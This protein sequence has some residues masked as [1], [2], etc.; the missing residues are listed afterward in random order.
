ML[1]CSKQTRRLS[2]SQMERKELGTHE[3]TNSLL[4]M[5]WKIAV[6]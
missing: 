3:L 6:R 2:A 5:G 4:N 1:N